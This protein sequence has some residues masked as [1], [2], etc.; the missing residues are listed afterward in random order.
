M[1]L[2]SAAWLDF[3]I[4]LGTDASSRI[5]GVGPVNAYNLIEKHRTIEAVLGS[6]N[7]RVQ[8]LE[9]KEGFM[10]DVEIARKVFT[11]LPPIPEGVVLEDGVWDETALDAWLEKE[12]G[13]R[14]E[15]ELGESLES[16]GETP[17]DLVRPEAVV[18]EVGDDFSWDDVDVR[19]IEQSR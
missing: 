18:H 5:P 9:D 13:I 2:D 3:C 8:A 11:D 14:F 1:N 7:K 15:D 17:K 10:R 12:H 16:P 6:D 4:L 19:D